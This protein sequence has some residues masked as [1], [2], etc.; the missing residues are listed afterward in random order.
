M[1]KKDRRASPLLRRIGNV[2]LEVEVP[3]EAECHRVQL[4]LPGI[5][6][7]EAKVGTAKV[8]GRDAAYARVKLVE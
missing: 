3:T 6:V 1:T 7:Q 8:E 4:R 2:R 5:T